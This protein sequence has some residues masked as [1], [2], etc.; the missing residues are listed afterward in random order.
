METTSVYIY[1]L[2]ETSQFWH[3]NDRELM[4]FRRVYDSI[5]FLSEIV[6]MYGYKIGNFTA[7][8]TANLHLDCLY[9]NFQRMIPHRD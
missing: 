7:D 8:G 1:N 2:I 9:T 3:Q 6:A 4:I 5:P